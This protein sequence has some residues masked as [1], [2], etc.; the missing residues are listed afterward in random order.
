[1]SFHRR[2]TTAF[3]LKDYYYSAL[4]A[5]SIGCG[6][7]CVIKTG[8]VISRT[9]SYEFIRL[10]WA[11]KNSQSVIRKSENSQRAYERLIK[12]GGKVKNKFFLRAFLRLFRVAKIDNDGRFV[13][14]GSSYEG[15]S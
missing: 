10:S 5:D 3:P 8:E 12:A 9:N 6:L 13:R 15:A 1:M 4:C 7:E 11:M 2:N 14:F